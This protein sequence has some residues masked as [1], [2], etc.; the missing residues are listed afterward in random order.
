MVNIKGSINRQKIND[1]IELYFQ[2]WDVDLDYNMDDEYLDLSIRVNNSHSECELYLIISDIIEEI[3]ISECLDDVIK[4]RIYKIYKFEFRN[5]SDYVIN[6]IK[7]EIKVSDVYLD[8]KIKM[9][10]RL[11]HFI[12]EN[13]SLDIDGYL[14]FRLKEYLYILD[15]AIDNV[16]TEIKEEE[17]IREILDTIKFMVETNPSK[18]DVLHLVLK[19]GEFYFK[20]KDNNIVGSDI[21]NK[22]KMEFD[23]KTVSKSDI[24]LSSLIL[25]SP[26]EVV[27]HS[28]CGEDNFLIKAIE[29]IFVDRVTLCKGCSICKSDE[30]E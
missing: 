6:R 23:T 14:K 7:D 19:N 5:T 27:V 3:I 12:E 4:E 26:K 8:E 17:E 15:V 29:E 18:E 30:E 11:V 21:I 16:V 22:V 24:L 2:D 25:I 20:D 13:K 28:D 9:K 10:D 1:I